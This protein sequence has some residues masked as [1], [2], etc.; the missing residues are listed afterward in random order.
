MLRFGLGLTDLCKHEFGSDAELS[1]DAFDP[2][3][4]RRKL[5]RVR[6]AAIAFDSKTAGSG[7]L[8]RGVARYGRQPER[9]GGTAV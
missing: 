2:E 8:G 9:I 6:P 1:R 4:L 3:S 7:F 5:E